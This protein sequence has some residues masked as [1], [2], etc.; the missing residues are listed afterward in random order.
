MSLL[1]KASLVQIPSGYKST[2][3]Y[4]QIPSNGNGDF[5]FSRS[6]SGTRVNSEGLI[7]TASVVST[8]ELVTNGDF[9][10]SSNWNGVNANGVTISNG[11]LNYSSTPN[12][13]NITQSSVVEI[14]KKYKVTFTI[15]NYVKGG[16][17]VVLGA[18]GTTQEVSSNGT[19]SL[20][21]V[22]S[23]NTTL[24]LQARGA[25]GTTLS[26]DNVSV[27]EVIEN[28]VPRLD[29]SDGSCPS[30][31]LEPQRTNNIL[32]SNQ[33][34]TTWVLTNATIIGNQSGIFNSTDAWKLVGNGSNNDRINSNSLS[35]GAYTF[36]IYAKAG[37]SKFV[38]V[39][40]GSG[41]V[42]YNLESGSIGSQ[43]SVTSAS[44]ESVGNEW[45]RLNM[46]VASGSG[47][48]QVYIANAV[49]SVNTSNGDFIYLQHAQAE[50]G[51]YST[52]IIP[53]S[54]STVTR[55]ADS[56]ILTSASAL[57][58]QTQG[59]LYSEFD[60]TEDSNFT[61]VEVNLG[62]STSNRILAYR[63]GSYIAFIV[64]VGGAIEIN[65]STLVTFLETN[66][67]AITYQAN[68]FKIYLNGSLVKT[69]TS[70]SIPSSL[71]TVALQDPNLQGKKQRIKSL[72]LFKEILT[73]AELITLTTL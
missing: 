54:G 1:D 69:Y 65:N 18:G 23:I 52:S 27:K 45:Y 72:I 48:V 60:L 32:Q 63:N 20:Y 14:G 36:S 34:N 11:T 31:L 9:A 12:G 70:G 59:T 21:G 41:V 53:T 19:F 7:E 33:L 58:G 64:Q 15:S 25:S 55:T 35:S 43:A 5:T 50:V 56:G 71:D 39:V 47:S 30:L 62:N 6:S 10:S 17:L 3:L 26:I 68:N 67:I 51:S 29:Y 2:K 28:D 22:A 44:I 57:I 4:S 16:I 8:T 38:A 49:G 73:N 42:Y 37:N 13:T 61:F 66:K 24:Y 46:S 40:L